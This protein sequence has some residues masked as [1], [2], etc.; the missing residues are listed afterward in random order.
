MSEIRKINDILP[1]EVKNELGE[2]LE[3]MNANKETVKKY[4]NMDPKEVDRMCDFINEYTIILKTTDVLEVEHNKACDRRDALKS[5]YDNAKT[6][7]EANRYM[8]EWLNAVNEVKSLRREFDY[9][10]RQRSLR[11]D[12]MI[13]YDDK[14]T[15]ELERIK[16]RNNSKSVDDPKGPN[17]K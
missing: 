5:K 11:E 2:C 3:I 14:L 15:N 7:E 17:K 10:E 4:S 8:N 12:E 13:A 9:Y 16:A 6:K 1:N